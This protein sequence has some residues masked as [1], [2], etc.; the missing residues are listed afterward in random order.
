VFNAVIH[1][2]EE[3]FGPP[4][5]GLKIKRHDYQEKFLRDIPA[6]EFDPAALWEALEADYG[7]DAGVEAGHRQAAERVI[8]FFDLCDQ[9][10]IRRKKG[11]VVLSVDVYL[12]DFSRRYGENRLTIGRAYEMSSGLASLQDCAEAAG[13]EWL[14]AG[15]AQLRGRLSG[16]GFTE[17]QS[18]E[19]LHYPG[20]DV[21]TYLKRFEF[22][23][24]ADEAAKLQAFL[25]RYGADALQV[26]REGF[27]H[28][29][30]HEGAA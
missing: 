10:E 3:A 9:C 22:Q 19:R 24:E 28:R 7:G 14:A 16:P 15:A 12:D 17:I 25:G 20:F 2:A 5:G 18:R 26:R 6:S 27:A 13:A 21:V 11:R 1:A 4:G 29:H 23:L 8:R 30:R